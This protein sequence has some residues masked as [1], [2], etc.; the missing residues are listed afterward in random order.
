MSG[1]RYTATT[2]ADAKSAYLERLKNAEKKLGI[3]D[4]D[5]HFVVAISEHQAIMAAGKHFL[6]KKLTNDDLKA[7]NRDLLFELTDRK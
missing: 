3:Y 7:L 2:H 5:C 4:F 6:V 1:E